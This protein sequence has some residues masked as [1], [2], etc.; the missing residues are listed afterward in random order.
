MTE[1]K[2]VAFGCWNNYKIVDNSIPMINVSC[3]LKKQSVENKYSD[4][5]IL[6]D[7]YYPKKSII[8][9][10]KTGN[11]IKYT[12]FEPTKFQY[13]FKLIE[14]LDN[15]TN[16]F[17]IMGNHDVE[18]TLL[19]DCIGLRSQLDKTDKFII[20]FPFGTHTVNVDDIKFKYIFIDT[21][22]YNLKDKSETCFEKVN[23]KN[24]NNLFS[25]QNSFI[26]EELKDKT[27][28]TF[29]IF[30]HEP[31]ITLKTKIKDGKKE[32]KNNI[33]NKDL[34]K[35]LFDSKKDIVYVC[36]DV[37]MYQNSLI[38]NS[39]EQIIHQIVCGT[40]GADK[41]YYDSDEKKY[42]FGS[43]ELSEELYDFE[44]L[45]FDDAYGYVEISLKKTG[46]NH[47]YIKVNKDSLY[48][49]YRKTYYINYN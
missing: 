8:I 48:N 9:D 47:T 36:A 29:L 6:G 24:A 43:E 14:S 34:L 45:H 39:D 41:D 11:K 12:K 33:L 4:L 26:I 10:P 2:L 28:K 21:N 5:I 38:K 23:G 13:G 20:P 7:N 27:I 3:Y 30:G 19:D 17:L 16:K 15:I 32:V 31:L 44:L 40:G 25:D 49:K 18:D 37:H 1:H 22:I 35:I 46:V 42:K